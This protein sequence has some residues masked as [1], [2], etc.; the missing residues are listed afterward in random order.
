[1]VVLV[2]TYDIWA[3]LTL[4]CRYVHCPYFWGY[5]LLITISIQRVTIIKLQLFGVVNG[6]RFK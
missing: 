2:L 1:M 6:R 4:S 5:S 3:L